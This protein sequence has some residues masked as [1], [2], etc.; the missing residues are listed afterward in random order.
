MKRK[1]TGFSLIEIAI[2]MAIISL[3]FTLTVKGRELVENSRAESLA[4]DFR[5]IQSAVRSHQDRSRARSGDGSKTSTHPKG[6][7]TA[8]NNSN[9][10]LRID[11]KLNS[12]V[13]DSYSVWQHV[14]LT[15][16]LP[17]GG[18]SSTTGYV[19]MSDI[20]STLNMTGISAAPIIGMT[21]D[22]I[23]CSDNISGRLVLQLDM[24]MDDG[25]TATGSMLI[26]HT[27]YGGK[28]IS[29]SNIIESNTYLACLAA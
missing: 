14:R 17:K 2:S 3:L 18:D 1:Q 13:S 15:G 29:S 25:N 19:P 11:G 26:G 10:T 23:I 7:R 28:P 8:V 24:I 22:Y 20:D 9:G 27:P 21:D 16:L 5:G 6:S 4:R 12:A